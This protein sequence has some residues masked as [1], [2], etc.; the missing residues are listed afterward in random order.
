MLPK[1]FLRLIWL[2]KLLWKMWRLNKICL[3]EWRMLL[4]VEQFWQQ[5]LHL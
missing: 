5:T 1:L 3:I 2:L 4:R